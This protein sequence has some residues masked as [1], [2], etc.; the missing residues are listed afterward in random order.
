MLCEAVTL[1]RERREESGYCLILLA[2]EKA[3][4]TGP[5]LP[6]SKF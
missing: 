6:F 2:V 4:G 5:L 3:L 1:S